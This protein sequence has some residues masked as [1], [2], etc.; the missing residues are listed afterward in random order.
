[1]LT[2][3]RVVLVVAL[4]VSKVPLWMRQI[5]AYI[6]YVQIEVIKLRKEIVYGVQTLGI[7]CLDRYV[8]NFGSRVI[9]KGSYVFLICR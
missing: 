3:R 7:C 4:W 2:F 5:Y 1:M 6:S 9:C 8:L